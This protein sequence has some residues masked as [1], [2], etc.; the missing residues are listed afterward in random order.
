VIRN[1]CVVFLPSARSPRCFLFV[2]R[3]CAAETIIFRQPNYSAKSAIS[4]S[5]SNI[6]TARPSTLLLKPIECNVHALVYPVSTFFR[7]C[8]KLATVCARF[9]PPSGHILLPNYTAIVFPGRSPISIA[10]LFSLLYRRRTSRV[11]L[12]LSTGRVS[13]LRTC[14]CR[15]CITAGGL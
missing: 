9:W 14:T 11:N 10:I 7:A 3:Q 8:C 15:H 12:D 5:S 1:C 13:P 2:I 6:D 4:E